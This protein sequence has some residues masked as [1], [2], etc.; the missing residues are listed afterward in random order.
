MYFYFLAYSFR[1]VLKPANSFYRRCCK[2]NLSLCKTGVYSR[3]PSSK[4][5][6]NNSV[7]RILV[8][9]RLT[10]DCMCVSAQACL[11]TAFFCLTER[12]Y[13]GNLNMGEML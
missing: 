11:Y 1:L 8:W 4:Y 3:V 2:I 12:I 7:I 9:G 10:F 5:V 6:P 13:A